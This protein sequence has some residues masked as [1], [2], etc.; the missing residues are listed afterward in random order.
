MDEGRGGVLA[1]RE[2]QKC[3][4]DEKDSQK[5]ESFGITAQVVPRWRWP[6]S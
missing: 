4:L 2:V 6:L 5:A 1:L 3:L